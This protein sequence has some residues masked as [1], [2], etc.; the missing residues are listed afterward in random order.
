MT[1]PQ[2]QVRENKL[3]I[4]YQKIQDIT[5]KLK[6]A[7]VIGLCKWGENVQASQQS[8]K[9]WLTELKLAD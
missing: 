5:K 7:K 4:Y 8:V 6:K 2:K 1:L 3:V 9:L